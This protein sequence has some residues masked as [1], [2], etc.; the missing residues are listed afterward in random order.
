[1]MNISLLT[2]FGTM[3]D[4]RSDR[5]QRYSFSDLISMTILACMG[6]E[7]T[8]TGMASFIALHRDILQDYFD[9]SMG[10]PSHDCIR[11]IMQSLD[12]DAFLEKLVTFAE[13]VKEVETRIIAVDG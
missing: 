9:L 6:G 13:S 5:N 1:M 7:S 10:T 12:P 2:R 4:P 3:E 11:V 8:Y